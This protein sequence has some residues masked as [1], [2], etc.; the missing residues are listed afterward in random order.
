MAI[1]HLQMGAAAANRLNLND[2]AEQQG[3]QQGQG[4]LTADDGY[5]V[6][7]LDTFNTANTNSDYNHMQDLCMCN[8][9]I[10]TFSDGIKKVGAKKSDIIYVVTS[11]N[12]LYAMG[13]FYKGDGSFPKIYPEFTYITGN[14]LDAHVD[15]FG[16]FVI[17]TGNNLYACGTNSWGNHLVTAVSGSSNFSKEFTFYLDAQF[18]G[19][20]NAIDGG[21]ANEHHMVGIQTNGKL[22]EWGVSIY[23]IGS[24]N[25]LSSIVEHNSSISD[26]SGLFIGAEG[27]YVTRNNGDA[28]SWG[29]N[30]YANN[31]SSSPS[32]VNGI[33]NV[34]TIS[35]KRN[36]SFFITSDKK[37]YG[38]GTNYESIFGTG[39]HG[40]SIVGSNG[41]NSSTTTTSPVYLHISGIDDIAL[42]D[43]YSNIQG[44]YY[45][46]F[47]ASVIAVSGGNIYG[48]GDPRHIP[49]YPANLEN[50]SYL[51]FNSTL[52]QVDYFQ[53]PAL[54]ETGNW[55]NCEANYGYR[56]VWNSKELGIGTNTIGLE[57]LWFTSQKDILYKN[58]TFFSGTAH[59]GNIFQNTTFDRSRTQTDL[60]SSI[61]KNAYVKN[62]ELYSWG[63][64]PTY[65]GNLSNKLISYPPDETGLTS[66]STYIK[67]TGN[68]HTLLYERDPGEL[69][70]PYKTSPNKANYDTWD[71]VHNSKYGFT[72]YKNETGY[73]LGISYDLGD[74]TADMN[75]SVA[76]VDPDGSNTISGHNTSA[77]VTPK[78]VI[79]SGV[80][81][82]NGNP[83]I[84]SSTI[85]TGIGNAENPLL[86][87]SAN[88]GHGLIVDSNNR[89]Y[90]DGKN[91]NGQLGVGTTTANQPQVGTTNFYVEVSGVG[92]IGSLSDSGII[93]VFTI[94]DGP[95]GPSSY[96]LSSGGDLFGWGHEYLLGYSSGNGNLTTPVYVTGNVKKLIFAPD[97][98]DRYIITHDNKLYSWGHNNYGGCLLGDTTLRY[99]PTQVGV[100]SDW[101]DIYILQPSMDRG[102][103]ISL[104]S[105]GYQTPFSNFDLFGRLMILEKTDGTYYLAG[106]CSLFDFLNH[107]DTNTG[108]HRSDVSSESKVRPL[109]MFAD[110]GNII[111][112]NSRII[113]LNHCAIIIPPSG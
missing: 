85:T 19:S 29:S 81:G 86:S 83:N 112:S 67:Y 31:F 104:S 95:D 10:Y 74:S 73:Y 61:F 92:T 62:G 100:D 59:T 15:R 47:G 39:S 66:F 48:W 45:G 52:V 27:A 110:T 99:F 38:R 80:I 108:I 16:T 4:S 32:L 21:A 30:F 87:R 9:N 77:H 7:G 60:T 36:A 17:D 50:A 11:G 103:T 33:S 107:T 34:N 102:Q 90:A 98:T 71:R 14:V 89:I 65:R 51:T 24:P 41:A 5:Y 70:L 111:P 40:V 53:H 13:N 54:M 3:Q 64:S 26:W 79:Y 1:R 46:D 42:I 37:L 56:A 49:H 35:H 96:A 94:N 8:K 97:E 109:E 23:E 2:I 55:T 91:K 68:F 82:W 22:Y 76:M 20:W 84:T 75:L 58:A 18:S 101:S 12:E 28:Y 106:N 78:H 113:T 69:F 63:V 43:G 44:M 57:G 88:N 72:A 25:V 105:E 93:E 6:L